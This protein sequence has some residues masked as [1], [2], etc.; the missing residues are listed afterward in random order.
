M[1]FLFYYYFG[2]VLLRERRKEVFL[3]ELNFKVQLT[4]LDG[5]KET[6]YQYFI[7][8]NGVKSRIQDLG[9]R[10]GL[11]VRYY[12]SALCFMTLIS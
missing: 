8:S 5:N 7:V 11:W 2:L 6:N 12:P 3:K 4:Y 1:A 9:K 10:A